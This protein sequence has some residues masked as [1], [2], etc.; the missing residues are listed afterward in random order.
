MATSQLTSQLRA[1]IQERH[2]ATF[3]A[4]IQVRRTQVAW[5]QVRPERS[6]WNTSGQALAVIFQEAFEARASIEHIYWVPEIGTSEPLT[7]SAALSWFCA[8][9]NTAQAKVHNEYGGAYLWA[10]IA[11]EY[12]HA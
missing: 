1:S 3:D 2:G 5:M 7:Q 11:W 4:V 12:D 9:W 6:L 8:W 10:N